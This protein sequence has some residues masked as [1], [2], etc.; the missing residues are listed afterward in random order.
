MNYKGEVAKVE[1]FEKPR[2]EKLGN[3]KEITFVHSY[4]N[5]SI[6]GPDVHAGGPCDHDNPHGHN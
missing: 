6:N 3:I 4:W 1:S 2:L 5:C